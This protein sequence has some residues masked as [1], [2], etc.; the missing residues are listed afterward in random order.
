M[1][2]SPSGLLQKAGM[3]TATMDQVLRQEDDE[4]REAVMRARHGEPGASIRGLREDRVREVPREELGAEAARCW[5]ALAAEERADTAVMAPTH[6]IRRQT[7]EA[8]RQGLA[9]EGTLHGRVLEVDRLVN[10]HLTRAEAAGIASYEPGDTVVFHRNAYGCEANDVCTVTGKRDG[11]VILLHPDGG[12]RS[13]RPAGNA[14][15][16]LGLFDT[17]RIELRAGDRIRWTRNRKPPPPRGGNPPQPYLVNGG[18]AEIVEI[19]YERVRF[20]DGDGE[21][22]LS[23]ADPQLRHLDHAYCTTVHAAQGKTARA[24]IAVL[25][26]GGAADQEM[27]HVEIS[28]V[29]REFLLLTDDREALIELLEGRAGGEEGALEALGIDPSALPSEDAE[30]LAALERDWRALEREARETATVAFFLPGYRDAM[31][32]AAALAA[33]G[34]LPPELSR[35]VDRML[36]EHRTASRARPG[37]SGPGEAHPGARAALAGARLGGRDARGGRDRRARGLARGR[38]GDGGGRPHAARGWRRRAA[39]S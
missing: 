11:R 6:E 36:A 16:Y 24:A 18:E 1:R 17:E 34:G 23:R 26:A 8:I 35:L 13:F 7:N 14:K 39:P 5:L 12:E 20:R 15:N 37:G 33:A 32:R 38:G 29:R 21:F 2:A 19:G 10:R 3:N 9:E 22:S 31:A 28:R 30:I 25:D 27:F 4:L